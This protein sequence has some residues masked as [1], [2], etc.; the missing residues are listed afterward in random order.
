VLASVGTHDLPRFTSFFLGR[1]IGEREA[2]GYLA[3]VDADG[4]RAQRRAWARA[5]CTRIGVPGEWT[6]SPCDGSRAGRTTQHDGAPD[7]HLSEQVAELAYARC[8]EHLAASDA[9]LVLIDVEEA[10]G[11]EE[12]QNRPGTSGT[13]P[14]WRRRARYSLAE[15][16]RCARLRDLVEQ[17]G[18]DRDEGAP[19]RRGGAVA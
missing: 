15:L 11:E 19:G 2:A 9:D 6:K 1:D 13:V 3:P 5:L 4:E 8:V 16:E 14:N 12:P 17:I 18:H 10:W 7:D